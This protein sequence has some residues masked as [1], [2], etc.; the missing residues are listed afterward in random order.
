M[1]KRE[2]IEEAVIEGDAD[3]FLPDDKFYTLT[4]AEILEKQGLK[5]DALKIYTRLLNKKG[6]NNSIV[7]ER[8]EKLIHGSK[9]F[10][11]YYVRDNGKENFERWIHKLQKGEA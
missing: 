8:I 2:H 7:R 1:S 9:E 11:S 6:Q 3:D 5:K 10:S 4:M